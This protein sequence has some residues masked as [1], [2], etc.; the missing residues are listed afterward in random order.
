MQHT[1]E[2]YIFYSCV[3]KKWLVDL[4]LE[5]LKYEKKNFTAQRNFNEVLE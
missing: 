3:Q 4:F 2:L 1:K 5:D